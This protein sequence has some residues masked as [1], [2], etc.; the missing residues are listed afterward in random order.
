MSAMAEPASHLP[1]PPAPVAAAMAAWPEGLRAP[2]GVLRRLVLATAA[3]TP[4][5]G[6][7]TEALRWGEVS[8]LTEA[9]GAGT[10]V[11]IGPVRGSAECYAMFVHCRTGLVARYRDLYGGVLRLEGARAVV[12]DRRAPLPEGPVAHCIAMALR[13]H[14]DRRGR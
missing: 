3:A 4:G 2:L 7:L 14:A 1:A 11:R 6:P 12:F 10:T 8:F 5:V 13:Y 9:T